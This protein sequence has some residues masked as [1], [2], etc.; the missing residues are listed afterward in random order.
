VT[1]IDAHR[2][3]V[4]EYRETAYESIGSA[5]AEYAMV[6][7][8]PSQRDPVTKVYT[9]AEYP[10]ATLTE[11]EGGGLVLRDPG[12]AEV[13]FAPDGR[14][15]YAQDAN[16]NRTT[17]VYEN[18]RLV[19]IDL[20]NGDRFTL[21]YTPDGRVS[22]T[23][24]PVGS[25]TTYA[26]D[27]TG[28][29][30]VSVTGPRGTT[31]YTYV[32]EDGSPAS[33]APASV[34]GSDGTS[35]HYEY[36]TAGRL[37]RVTEADGAELVS[38][39]YGDQGEVTA[40]AEDGSSVTAWFLD[41]G[42]PARLLDSRGRTTRWT[43]DDN[44]LLTAVAVSDGLYSRAYGYDA[45]RNMTDV[46][47]AGGG[48]IQAAYTPDVPGQLV[49]LWDAAGQGLFLDHDAN[50]NLT[51]LRRADGR[52]TEF[53]YDDGG[54]L[55]AVR[56]PRGVEVAFGYHASGNLLATRTYSDG[57]ALTYTYNDARNLTAISDGTGTMSFAYDSGGRVT[58]V[59]YPDGRE[60]SY[61]YDSGGRRTRLETDDGFVLLY[62]YD[63]A[64]RLAAVET[65][66][67]TSV[68]SYGY[69]SAGRLARVDKGNGAWTELGYDGSGNLARM[70]NH[71]PDR[72]VL[73]E[74][75]N[76]FDGL[77]RRTSTQ[78]LDGTWT[79]SYDTAGRLIQAQA[80][81]GSLFEY[82][83][84]QAGNRVTAVRDGVETDYRTDALNRYTR[85][86]TWNHG[87]DADGNLVSRENGTDAWLYAYTA[88]GLLA[89]VTGPGTHT[90][91]E[92]DLVG[93][94]RARVHN[95]VRTEYLID[96]LAGA[97]L[98]A[99]YDS[100]GRV[101]ARYAGQLGPVCRWSAAGDPA[102]YDFDPAGNT[103]AL[104]DATGATLN[105]Y[106][107]TP[108]GMP[109]NVS[110]TVDNPFRFGGIAG[111]S[112]GPEGL[113]WAR[114]RTYAPETGRFLSEDLQP[115]TG[116]NAYAY[117]DNDPVNLIDTNGMS[118]WD[119]AW[120]LFQ[121]GDGVGRKLNEGG[122]GL[123]DGTEQIV[124]WAGD[125][126][127]WLASGNLAVAENALI[128]S[129]LFN[130]TDQAMIGRD[131][132]RL[133][134]HANSAG[135]P[136]SRI[137]TFLGK[138]LKVLAV[139]KSLH[140]LGSDLY[141]WH[142]GKVDWVEPACS[143][144]KTGGILMT[145]AIGAGTLGA[146]LFGAPVAVVAGVLTGITVA[147]DTATYWG[148]EWYYRTF[149][150]NGTMGG[151]IPIVGSHD[152]ND[153][154]GPAGVGPE[155]WVR[156]GPPLAYRIRF[157][158]DPEKATAPAQV[159]EVTL[160]LDPDLDWET[161]ELR[162]FGFGDI[163]VDVPAGRQR[164]EA[165][166]GVAPW[167]GV[168]VFFHAE[169]DLETGVVTWLFLSVDPETGRVPDDPFVGFLP[170]NVESPEGEGFVSFA[171]H[172]RDDATT[173]TSVTAEAD[174]VFDQNDPIVTPEVVNA[175]D[176]ETP[177][178]TAVARKTGNGDSV[179]LSM[180]MDDHGGSG[181]GCFEVYVGEPGDGEPSLWDTVAETE[182][183]YP[184]VWGAS[185]RFYVRAVD[186]VGHAEPLP[187][188]PVAEVRLPDWAFRFEVTGAN[189]TELF[190]A[191][192]A[193]ATAGLDPGLDEPVTPTPTRQDGSVG[194]Y[195]PGLIEPLAYDV[196][197]P[198][199]SVQWRLQA[200]PA[201]DMPLTL[202]WDASGIPA[203]RY[204]W[205]AR[206]DAED[207]P[208]PETLLDLRE[209]NTLEVP[210]A[211]AYCLTLSA[212]RTLGLALAQG[213]NLVAV[214]VTP[215]PADPAVVFQGRS[216]PGALWR[217]S[218]DTRGAGAYAAVAEVQALE[219]FWIWAVV[220]GSLL[221]T[222]APADAT[223]I[224]LSPGWNVVAVAS[225]TTVPDD[226]RVIGPAWSWH[227]DPDTPGYR[228]VT[229]MEPGRGYWL[230]LSGTEPL[231]LE[232]P[233]P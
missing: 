107:Y 200:T 63:S 100:A 151:G 231:T 148:A 80:P 71:G 118:P 109:L 222:G 66:N 43:Y 56:D 79:Y 85:A 171:V 19:T 198:A 132:G 53:S 48:H 45:D 17:A 216:M 220:D 230:F 233:G 65:G 199:T 123:V 16:R 207:Q 7:P 138:G 159:V 180:S 113:V 119:T 72:T 2:R 102:Y 134:Q 82:A 147:W 117:A 28:G 130:Y 197:P 208:L 94:P 77:G 186:A 112:T 35:L 191:T 136:L 172:A 176:R 68:V 10:G 184:G 1:V 178:S 111:L 179:R 54:R 193:Q 174:I 74:F 194:W 24:D 143:F 50:G 36:D 76:T 211:D 227:A 210:Q 141:N 58:Q 173:G 12:G 135:A 6:L 169:L 30:L 29:H 52:T 166:L 97:S 156:A 3:L 145:T 214:P 47:E 154:I 126:I 41:T 185:Y 229:R 209:Q 101:T 61:G 183:T 73:S 190:A 201:D 182:T 162:G 128:K 110:E 83:Y 31:E 167:L 26:Y 108:F 75:V 23:V 137:G 69:D 226:P 189:V 84:D 81:D 25:V 93:N 37:R 219:G 38:Y 27:A 146:T 153:I 149:Y 49:S 155:N 95:G 121:Q 168:D 195:A 9:C 131:W 163:T 20:A 92:Y 192:H 160:P 88:D 96:P 32:T 59:S 105:R 217:W 228:P 86:G 87:H 60:L 11:G 104:T 103:V 70:T 206:L 125:A 89:E 42:E 175:L 98:V 188:E 142:E 4:F 218:A 202:S 150:P 18:G 203:D 51:A 15:L 99:E 224:D 140:S 22:Q 64:G 232:V 8:P 223:T 116:R 57:T 161:F 21:S 144:G 120:Y 129:R 133:A 34:T 139:A 114:T 91:Y 187:R 90:V 204:L 62:G 5:W 177:E 170:P 196:R 165:M 122:W 40:T 181:L 106:A 115:F 158:N 33:H 39:A 225:T 67:Q 46:Y 78:T 13:G 164:Y 157:E 127:N 14:W 44:G 215:E 124:S 205:L 212:E 152:P 213:W 221:V 55:T